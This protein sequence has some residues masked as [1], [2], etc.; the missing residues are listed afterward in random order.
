MNIGDIKEFINNFKKTPIKTI[1]IVLVV[2]CIS[3]LGV[4]LSALISETAKR[5][6]EKIE[7]KQLKPIDGENDKQVPVPKPPP[8]IS[9]SELN[10]AFSNSMKEIKKMPWIITTLK[11]SL[12]PIVEKAFEDEKI[13]HDS[14]LLIANIYRLYSASLFMPSQ[15]EIGQIREGV[16]WIRRAMALYP[17]WSDREEVINAMRFFQSTLDGKSS[18]NVREMLYHSLRIGMIELPSQQVEN[19]TDERYE[20]IVKLFKN[21][22]V[23]HD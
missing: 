14:P 4:Y 8:S 2:I 11:D 15:G 18:I 1:V 21:K 5:H 3:F 7:Q 17:N 6:V 16:L 12:H 20:I 13:Q 19:A 10:S 22:N 9:I 23:A